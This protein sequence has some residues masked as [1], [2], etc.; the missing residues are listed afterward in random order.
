MRV[1]DSMIRNVI[2]IGQAECIATAAKKMSETAVGCLVVTSND[3]VQGIITDRD[4]IACLAQ[5]HDPH[6]CAVCSHM[7]RPVI[8]LGPD[9][10][11]ATA[12]DVMRRRR[13][14]RLP[15]AKD[16]KLLGIVSLSDL[17]ALADKEATKLGSSLAFFSA[18]VRAQSSQHN[19][20]QTASKKEA[21]A[22]QFASFGDRNNQTEMCD[23]GGPG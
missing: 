4:L 20:P 14:K 18:V 3:S 6:G 17:A 15:V 9:E 7:R 5:N 11:V 16:G 19:L 13:I 8:V 22:A 1:E 23:I 2:Q 21:S 12:A 10:D